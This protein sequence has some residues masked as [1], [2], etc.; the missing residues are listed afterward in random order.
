M[1]RLTVD[2]R[3]VNAVNLSTFWPMEN[4]E[5]EL[6]GTRGSKAFAQVELCSGY[7]QALLHPE[8]QTYFAFRT[9]DEVLMPT[10][11]AQGGCSSATSFQG[12]VEQCF[13]ELMQHL[14]A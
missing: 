13:A 5:A 14:K 3:A 7:W 1:Y 12:K 8:S 4:I 6:A 9:L 10:R 2:Y 11:T